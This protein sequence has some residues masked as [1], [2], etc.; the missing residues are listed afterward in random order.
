MSGLTDLSFSFCGIVDRGKGCVI[1]ANLD[2]DDRTSAVPALHMGT[3]LLA[4]FQHAN[5]LLPDA[6]QLLLV[7]SRSSL[8]CLLAQP[9]M[10]AKCRTLHL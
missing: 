5:L 10:N 4:C 3:A 1:S 2:F 7:S 6:A 8:T 9:K